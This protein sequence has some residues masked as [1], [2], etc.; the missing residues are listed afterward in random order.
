L[1]EADEAEA[2]QR[3]QAGGAQMFAELVVAG[4]LDL[5]GRP[6]AGRGDSDQVPTLV[7]EGQTQQA[8]GSVLEAVV[9]AVGLSRSGGGWLYSGRSNFY[10]EL[11]YDDSAIGSWES[12]PSEVYG[13]GAEK[14]PLVVP[15]G[16]CCPL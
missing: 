2:G 13:D 15:E 7:G 5:A 6:A 4:C 11:I 8:V 10:G 9:L 3:S 14:V 16:L 12:K 1:I